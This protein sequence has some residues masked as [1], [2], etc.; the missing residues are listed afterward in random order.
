[1]NHETLSRSSITIVLDYFS[2]GI[3]QVIDCPNISVMTIMMDD[4]AIDL[5]SYAVLQPQTIYFMIMIAMNVE[6]RNKDD[7]FECKMGD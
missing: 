6:D 7:I 3:F 4:S 5:A 2:N 1:M